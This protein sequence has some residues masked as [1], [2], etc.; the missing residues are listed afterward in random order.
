MIWFNF[1]TKSVNY[2]LIKKVRHKITGK[3][4]SM[5]IIKRELIEVEED[6]IYFF[7]ELALVRSLDHPNI[8]KLYEFYQDDKYFYLLSE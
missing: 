2:G 1:L 8:I 4:R 7:K 6:E 3:I 5:K